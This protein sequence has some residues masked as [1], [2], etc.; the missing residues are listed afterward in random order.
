VS[1]A[2]RLTAEALEAS[3]LRRL[4]SGGSGD[5]LDLRLVLRLL[6]RCLRLLR[7]VRGHV[8]RL[9]AGVSLAFLVGLPLGL[10]FI[11]VLWTRVLEGEPLTR[12]EALFFG[13]EPARFVEVEALPAEA[14]RELARRW[15]AFGAPLVMLFTGLALAF[16]YYQ[17]WILQ[18][19]NQLLRVELLERLQSLSLRFHAE[20]RIGDA[21]YRL[22]QDSAMVTQLID[23]LFIQPIQLLAR[24][25]V[26]L[27]LVALIEPLL[28]L[29]LLA[30]WPPLLALGALFSRRLRT[31]F[32][33]AR[34]SQSR[35]TSRI[36]ETLA[37]IRVIK[38]YGAEGFEQERFE[39]D[40]REA[41]AAAF[42]ARSRFAVFK[43]ACFWVVG[44]SMIAGAAWGALHAV[45]EER[46]FGV[47]LLGV[48]GFSAWNLG[49][50]NWFK[51]HFGGGASSLRWL[52]GLWGR[53]QDVAIGLDRV[54]AVLDLEPEV[55]DPPDPVPVPALAQGVSFRQ[56]RFR[57][58]PDRPAVEG[59]SFEAPVGAVTAVVGATGSGKS[60]LMAL[61]LRLFDPGEGGIALDGIDLRRFRVAE[62]RSRIAIALQE[63]VLFGTTI[64][65]N[66]RYAVP[67]APDAR[68]REA[69]R[70]A[71]ADEFAERLPDAYDTELGERGTRL[72]TGQRQRLS[73][74]RAVLK[75]APILILD[76]PTASLDAE[77][78]L[79]VLGNLAA[80][81]RGRVIFL[82]T[83]RLS[84]IRRADQVVV[85]R[86][87]R[88][89]ECGAPAELAR[90]E[91][92]WLRA[93][94]DSE[95]GAA[96]ARRAAVA[97]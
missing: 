25:V 63:N 76:E 75:D 48:L 6:W 90:R 9:L 96:A 37:G 3:K 18:R 2:E 49:V 29:L 73:I 10:L 14:R 47:F 70:V 17:I 12:P 67:D 24:F 89:V 51:A 45:G 74:A 53:T 93:L 33:G 32:R 86:E 81:G 52:F 21:I 79:R 94:L 27:A 4:G 38:A 44:A 1:R 64:R 56:V 84:T 59:V 35:L 97:S 54:F 8:A 82:V 46:L 34:E 42:E 66:I 11:D 5:R 40:S 85:L 43:V 68:V 58:Q 57:Y 19:V 31:G 13:V 60:T 72:S 28:A 78:E 30:L 91:G 62:L 95:E 50:Y 80:W 61:L 39:R 26:S 77:T 71:C 20:S 83:H 16:G 88:L 15:I 69:A 92:G 7:P 65:E 41:F 55:Q 22:Y 23:V 36:Q 87:G